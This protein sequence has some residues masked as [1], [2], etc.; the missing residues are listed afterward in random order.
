MGPSNLWTLWFSTLC[1]TPL[2]GR[3]NRQLRTTLYVDNMSVLCKQLVPL[4]VIAGL[5]NICNVTQVTQDKMKKLQIPQKSSP[6]SPTFCPLCLAVMAYQSVHSNSSGFHQTV[7]INCGN[8]F[9]QTSSHKPTVWYLPCMK[10]RR[11][12]I[13][14]Y[15]V[16]KVKHLKAKVTQILFSGAEKWVNI[17]LILNRWWERRLQWGAIVALS[18]FWRVFCASLVQLYKEKLILQLSAQCQHLPQFYCFL[19]VLIKDI[20]K[21]CEA[22][23]NRTIS[24]IMEPQWLPKKWS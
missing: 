6:K 18:L 20:L 3:V 15:L 14:E 17:G 12:Q 5:H 2:T 9:Q 11:A 13:N 23:W 19:S 4:S 7:H 16:K 24:F 1:L 22:A 21:S 8:L 10:W